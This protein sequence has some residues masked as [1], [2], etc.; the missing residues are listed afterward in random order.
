[1]AAALQHLPDRQLAGLVVVDEQD[2]NDGA[3]R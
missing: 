3:R 1:V 2:A